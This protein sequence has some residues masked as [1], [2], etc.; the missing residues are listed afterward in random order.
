MTENK[1][2]LFGSAC[3]NAR[4]VSKRWSDK[5]TAGH[6]KRKSKKPKDSKP[7]IVNDVARMREIARLPRRRKTPCLDAFAELI[8]EGV[9]PRD[10]AEQTG[11][12]R[13]YGDQMMVRLRAKVGL[14]A[15]LV[16]DSTTCRCLKL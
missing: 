7:K 8:A 12:P 1:Q 9:S 2:T 4:A 6:A 15:Q 3:A 10:A 13:H 11:H 16:C 5:R 14:Q